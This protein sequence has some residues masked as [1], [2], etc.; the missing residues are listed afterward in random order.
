[1]AKLSLLPPLCRP[2]INIIKIL[3]QGTGRTLT[4][5]LRIQNNLLGMVVNS[6]TTSYPSTPDADQSKLTLNRDNM[7]KIEP[8]R[9]NPWIHRT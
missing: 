9:R 7:P 5:T 4:P 8:P 1:M 3:I 6:P 2:L